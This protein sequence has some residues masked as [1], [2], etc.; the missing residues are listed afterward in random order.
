MTITVTDDGTLLDKGAEFIT[1]EIVDGQSNGLDLHGAAAERALLPLVGPTVFLLARHLIRRLDEDQ[2]ATGL[3]VGEIA[4]ALG[5]PST[6][7]RQ[8]IKRAHRFGVLVHQAQ[9]GHVIVARRWTD[10][11]GRLT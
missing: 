1:V 5:V 10:P 3:L 8:A 7:V 6:K 4:G 11:K 9:R 2:V